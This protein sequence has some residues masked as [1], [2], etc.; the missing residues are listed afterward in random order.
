MAAVVPRDGM[1]V[2]TLELHKELT[3]RLSSFKVPR[4]YV[5]LSRNE[6]PVLHS[7]KVSRREIEKLVARKLAAGRASPGQ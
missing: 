7:N 3:R 5:I 6:V 2:D 1:S 4:E